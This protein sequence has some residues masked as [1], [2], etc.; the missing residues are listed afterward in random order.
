MKKLC[1]LITLLVAS[2]VAAFAQCNPTFTWA[3]TPSGNNLLNVTFTN[4]TVFIPPNPFSN[5]YYYMDFGDNSN[6]QFQTTVDHNYAAPGTYNATLV[7]FSYDSLQ[8]TYCNDSITQQI[9]VGYTACATS[10]SVV[11]QGN[12]VYVF[13]ASTPAGTTGM[14]YAWDFGD[15]STG[16]GN[17]VT[18]TYSIGTYTINLIA[19]GGGCTYTNST[20]VQSTTGV[21]NCA[22]LSA[23]IGYNVNNNIVYFTNNSTVSSSPSIS[24]VASWQFGDGGTSGSNNP[25]HTYTTGGVY[26]IML[27]NN[28]VDSAT[29]QTL[30]SDTATQVITVGNPPPVPNVISGNVY[31]DSS[32]VNNPYQVT[33]KV[34][35][36]V[37]DSVANTLTAIDSAIV[38]GYMGNG[39][40]YSFSGYPA[41]DYRTKAAVLNG[42]PGANSLIPTYHDVS[43]Y[44]NNALIINHTGGSSTGKNIMMQSGIATSGPG[45]VGGNISQGANKGT[46]VGV[47]NLLVTIRDINDNLIRFTYTDVNGNYSF[48]NLSAGSYTVYPEAMNYVTIPS[49]AITI[50]SGHYN[51]S[52]I[53]FKQTPTHIKPV[54]TGVENLAAATLFSVYPNPS[55]GQVRINW[56]KNSGEAQITVANMVGQEVFRSSALMNSTTVLDLNKL[57]TGVYFIRVNAG[58]TQHTEKI[59]INK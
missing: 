53:N 17:P 48:G 55:N 26:T 24:R 25:T 42:T 28:W 47:P 40:P 16:T 57:Q 1:L 19:T 8:Q 43:F 50:A 13:T 4:T 39:A 2:G 34:W 36:I 12:G 7:M 54:T 5:A 49:S 15:G 31:W 20:T 3:G 45:F 30:C 59:L 58:T 23:A 6:M 37:Q 27:I 21:L 35:L 18:H 10:I 38:S 46:A 52:G 56:M 22:S 33:F 11:N 44:W 29:Q 51:V 32:N 14:S 9:T 41:G